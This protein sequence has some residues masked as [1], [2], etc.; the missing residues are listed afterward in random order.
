[1]SVWRSNE[2]AHRPCVFASVC[3][4]VRAE[5]RTKQNKRNKK[6]KDIK[7]NDWRYFFIICRFPF[8]V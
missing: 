8:Q 1:M 4:C 5:R 3:V 6:E 7:I 2:C